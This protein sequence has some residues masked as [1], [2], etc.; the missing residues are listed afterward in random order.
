[1]PEINASPDRE[2]QAVMLIVDVA[3]R[4]DG[5]L[6]D[7]N[8]S[9]TYLKM[10]MEIGIEPRFLSADFIRAEP[11][12]SEL[13]KLG[14]ETLDGEWYR[15]NLEGWL[16]DQGQGI[17]YVLFQNPGPDDVVLSAIERCTRAALIC[18]IHDD[19]FDASPYDVLLV[20]SQAE[21]K[22]VQTQFPKK[23]ILVDPF[24][25]QVKNLDKSA[26]GKSTVTGSFTSSL[27]SEQAASEMNEVLLASREESYSR[28]AKGMVASN[29]QTPVRLIAFYL[30]QYHPIPENDEWWGDGFTEWHNVTKAKPLFSG[31]YQPHVPA[32]LGYYDLRQEETR[33][34]QADLAE[35]YGI[36]GFCY[37]HYWFKGKRLL[38]RPLK[39]L[40]SSGKPDFPFC[41]CWANESWSRR[42]DGKDQEILMKQEYSEQDDRVHIQSLLPLFADERYIRVNGK[43]LMLVYRTDNLPDP[44]RTA[45]IWRKEARNA[46]VGELYLCR[47]ES[48]VKGG[49]HE[50]GFDAS[51]EFAPDWWN[52][53]P[54]LNADSEVFTQVDSSLRKI[55]DN[56][57]IHSYQGLTEA[58]LAKEIP[59]YKW[60]RCVTPSWDNWARRN[61]GASVF[62]DSTPEKYRAW[63]ANT[64][65][66]ASE[67]LHGEER[68]VFINAWNEWA[69]GNHL[70]PDQKF[71]RAYLEATERALEDGQ[72]ATMVRW[73]K[74]RQDIKVNRLKVVNLS[75]QL[76]HLESRVDELEQEIRDMLNS[77]S[78]R[79]TGPL[80]WM[81]QQW[82]DLKKR[83]S[84]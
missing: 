3:G 13:N 81:K 11:F 36:E 4:Q 18:R 42:W 64:I 51:V 75:N 37:Y 78:W 54:Q 76:T 5:L 20:S 60:F 45:A 10:L 22:S 82:L 9:L 67:R 34:A 32:D 66:D 26:D 48:F 56:N 8:Q 41:I 50:I 74:S 30:P 16:K 29:G 6:A 69:E 23:K 65:D 21:Q 59:D 84:G 71:G 72:Q 14:C 7:G 73:L 61:E 17:E 35:K 47:V 57:F 52:K 44:A 19:G 27:V 58:M 43:P 39:E 46:G 31:H 1:M 68:I 15:H 12:S 25:E 83:F 24:F 40:I 49:P 79:M 28:I 38:E 2:R 55:C 63:L 70:E 77:T 53:G 62:L 80:R 33:I